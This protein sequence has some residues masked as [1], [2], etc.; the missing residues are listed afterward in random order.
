MLDIWQAGYLHAM[1][2]ADAWR[3]LSTTEAAEL[4]GVSVRNRRVMGR[5]GHLV[6]CNRP[7]PA[8]MTWEAR[9]LAADVISLRTTAGPERGRATRLDRLA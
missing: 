7:E 5:R 3:F 6:P 1:T 2:L 9:C 4:V 8:R